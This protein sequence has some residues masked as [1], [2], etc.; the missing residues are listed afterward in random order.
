MTRL[1]S[2]QSVL[3]DCPMLSYDLHPLGEAG[4]GVQ[5]H[6]REDGDQRGRR[7]HDEDRGGAHQ[8]RMLDHGNLHS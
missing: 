5:G 2:L 6:V 3:T 1:T 8:G 4:G 7:D